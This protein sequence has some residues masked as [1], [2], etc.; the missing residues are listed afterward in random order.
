MRQE[1][2]I[3]GVNSLYGENIG[4][5]G[6]TVWRDHM[7]VSLYIPIRNWR[8][9]RG[10]F[11]FPPF[12]E[13]RHHLSRELIAS[14]VHTFCRCL[15]VPCFRDSD[16]TTSTL[17]VFTIIAKKM[18]VGGAARYGQK[19]SRI[20][21]LKALGNDPRRSQDQEMDQHGKKT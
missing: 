21:F 14:F 9:F 13:R 1:H 8:Q 2:K 5:Q 19:N 3:F 6:Q 12:T 17:K 4:N 18:T 10:F 15:I 20:H 7:Y 16:P 11:F